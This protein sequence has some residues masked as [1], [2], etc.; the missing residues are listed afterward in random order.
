MKKN[1]VYFIGAGPGK[2]D[3]IT[4]R[5]LNILKEADVV[6]Y[7]YLVDKR[8][9]GYARE[10]AE[11][12]CCDKLAKKG[13]YYDGFLIHQQ[14]INNLIV[15]KA[16][17]GKKVVRLKNGDV[18]IFSRLSQELD[19]LV[20]NRIDFEL[21]PGVTAATA[22]ASYA[23]IPL[24]DRRFASTCTFVTGHEDPK[25]KISSIDWEALSKIGTVVFYMAVENLSEIVKELIEAGKSKDTACAIV[26]TATLAT[27]KVLSGK[28]E[29][30][31]EKA[32]QER[33]KPPAI[34]IVGDVVKSGKRFNWLKK[35]KKILFTGLSNERFFIKDTYFHLPLIKIEPMDDYREFDNYIKNIKDYDWIIFASRYCTEYFFKRLGVIGLDLRVLTGIRIAAV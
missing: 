15:K 28:L 29:N 26:R 19:A 24:T 1:K 7:D 5:G 23:G 25:K 32:K 30:I 16:K 2:P 4:V 6:I 31:A 18:S 35:N 14:R 13:R 21:V 9:L 34:I 10:E 20:R 22:A 12:I 3:L 27:Q 8:V 33:I 17:E 11:L